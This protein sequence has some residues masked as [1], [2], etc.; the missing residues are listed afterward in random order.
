MMNWILVIMAGV[1][2]VV[3]ALVVGGLASQRTRLVARE[4]RLRAPLETVWPLLTQ[5]EQTP[6]WCAH[7]PNMQL[8]MES[9]P[10]LRR[11]QLLDDDGV[12]FGEWIMA[13]AAH[14][15]GTQLSVTETCE[16]HNVIARF[17]NAFSID[18]SR[19]DDFLR[20]LALQ[21]GETDVTIG[22]VSVHE[23]PPTTRPA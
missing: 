12:A 17:F 14:D 3:L 22:S 6:A 23:R 1:V 5:V 10:R 18:S 16:L 19:V 21:V 9:A 7:L 15:G 13:A 11:L 8:L 20:A 4:V 2:A